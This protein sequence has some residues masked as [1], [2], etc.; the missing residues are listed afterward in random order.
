MICQHALEAFRTHCSFIPEPARKRIL[1]T[2]LSGLLDQ[3]GKWQY[4][5]NDEKSV[6]QGGAGGS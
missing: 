2:N 5:W 4:I 6:V 1:G 3:A